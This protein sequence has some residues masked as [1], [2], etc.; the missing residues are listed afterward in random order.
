MFGELDSSVPC[1]L[2]EGLFPVCVELQR[3]PLVVVE[4]PGMFHGV[5]RGGIK[6]DTPASTDL[7]SSIAGVAQMYSG[8][9]RVQ[10]GPSDRRYCCRD[11]IAV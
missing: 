8:P 9:R 6:S 7:C 3:F 5:M 10:T 2:N 11:L 4:N 1:T